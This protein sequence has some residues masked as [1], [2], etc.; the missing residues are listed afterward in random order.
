[1]F[2]PNMAIIRLATGKRQIYTQL[3]W[4]WDFNVYI[5]YYIKYIPI[6]N[7]G[8]KPSPNKC[9]HSVLIFLTCINA[10]SLDQSFKKI[11]KLVYLQFLPSL[12]QGLFTYVM[13][14]ILCNNICKALISQSH[15]NCVYMSSLSCG[16]P[17]EDH[18]WSKHVAD[19]WTK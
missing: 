4:D 11:W 14:I 1:M 18:T 3:Y 17:A 9:L 13:Y 10:F 12:F 19:L 6:H 5:C 15:Y 8:W 2:R 16:Q 7:R